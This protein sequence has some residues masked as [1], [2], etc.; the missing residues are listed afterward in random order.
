MVEVPLTYSSGPCYSTSSLLKVNSVGSNSTSSLSI[1]KWQLSVHTS[2]FVGERLAV[3]PHINETFDVTITFTNT[4]SESG[5]NPESSLVFW[6]R[7]METGQ[8]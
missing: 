2:I 7:K 5:H 6:P 3:L 1:L 4:M 8:G